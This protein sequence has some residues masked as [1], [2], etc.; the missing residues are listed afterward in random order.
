MKRRM[1][2]ALALAAA[3]LAAG[4]GVA[5]AQG[6]ADDPAAELK[7]RT[8]SG[9]AG[10]PG[11]GLRGGPPGHHGFAHGP[12][13]LEPAADY[14][15]LDEDTLRERLAAGDSLAEIAEAEG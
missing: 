13:F 3:G 11:L 10:L 12:G 14:L 6:R 15:G 8:R 9:E 5:V 1:Q 4:G 2:V 7:E